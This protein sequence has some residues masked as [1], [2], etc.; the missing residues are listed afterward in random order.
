MHVNYKLQNMNPVFAFSG[1]SSDIQL[2]V[3][4]A[5]RS[6]ESRGELSSYDLIRANRNVEVCVEFL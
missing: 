2:G 5:S 4:N 6:W 1:I 3:I